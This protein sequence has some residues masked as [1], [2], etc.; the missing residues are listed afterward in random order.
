MKDLLK[1]IVENLVDDASSISIKETTNE[2]DG[3]TIFNVSVSEEDFGKVIGK[4]GKI[5]HAIKIVAGTAALY[6]NQKV[7][8]KIGQE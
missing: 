8:I 1:L 3:I 4:K 6:Q 7:V 2:D 5:A